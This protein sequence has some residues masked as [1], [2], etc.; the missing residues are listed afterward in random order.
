MN[1]R[2][3][4]D[5]FL[6]AMRDAGIVPVFTRGGIE[7]DGKLVRFRVDGDRSG[8]RN[9]WAVLFGD[10]IPAGSF[11][12]YKRGIESSWCAKSE[13]AL[14]DDE[15]RANT[16]RMESA[17]RAR[18]AEQREREG[19]AARVANLLWNAAEPADD[20]HPYLVRKA[21]RA[22]GL[23]VGRWS[24]TDD[25][26]T[27]WLAVDRALLVPI[28][29]RRGKITSLQAIFP[30]PAPKIARDKDFIS[31]GKKRGGFFI[32]GNPPPAGGIVCICEG[33]ATAATI[34]ELTG[35]CCVVAFDAYNIGEVAR[36]MKDAMP[37]CSFVVA[38]DNDQWTM[39]PVENPGV[40]YAKRA[41]AEINARLVV[42]QFASLDGRPTD[43]NDLAN[44]EGDEV[45]QAQLLPST[46]VS[47]PASD[48]GGVEPITPDSV[49]TY[50]PFPDITGKGKPLATIRNARELLRRLRAT[51]RYNVVAKRLELLIPGLETSIDNGQNVAV[52]HLNSYAVMCG[53]PTEKLPEYL[54]AIGDSN[55]YNPVATWIQSR[56]WDGRTRLAE[57][58]ATVTERSDRRLPDGRSL[59][60]TLMR[61][62]LISAVAATFNPEGVVARGVLTFQSEQNLGKTLWAKRL[63]PKELRV[64]A[65]G[66]ILDP[67]DRDSVK[68]VVSNW[69]VEL[70]EVDAT[71]RK[72]DIA[73]LKAFVSKE[74]DT[75]R[76][77]YARAE[78][79]FPRRTVFFASVNDEQ[80]LHDPTGNTR[81]WTIPVVA[82]NNNHDIDVQQLWAEVFEL[83]R[84]GETWHLSREELAA[85]NDS[86]R[87]HEAINPVHEMVDRAFDW[88]SMPTLWTVP[89]TATEL[90]KAAGMDRPTKKD[91][92]E[93]AAHVTSRHGVQTAKKGKARVKVWMMPP[94]R[95]ERDGGPF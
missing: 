83:Y 40:H 54:L 39:T 4:I 30:E 61:R 55:Q 12:C 23:R 25:D 48:G 45:A 94:L 17:R 56:P 51:V 73:A 29:D 90:V 44:R 75:L 60:E 7:P 5:A 52:A 67:T 6:S 57:F 35:W 34:H 59:K 28:M 53:M 46:Q 33:Y 3:I 16:E 18:E 86:N 14:S 49:D 93:A 81:W 10:G 31:G 9:G 74:R 21:V 77:P 2:Q 70:G 50:T 69:I 47:A 84:T 88:D 43:F 78:S 24:K 72:A 87:D 82:L 19:E 71:F 20:S 27:E 95:R 58:Y 36:S 91:V 76:L 37:A 1:D 65:D 63:A 80:F 64:I 26:G 62:W 32:I 89:M 92:N 13:R 8:T 15:R 79:E 22:H 11:G 38:A 85:L 41:A 68:Q 66:L 42:P